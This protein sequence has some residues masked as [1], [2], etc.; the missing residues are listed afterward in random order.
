MGIGEPMLWHGGAC[1]PPKTPLHILRSEQDNVFEEEVGDLDEDIRG[2][3]DVISNLCY[4]SLMDVEHLLN[5]RSENDTLMESPTD[6]EIIQSVL[7]N[8]DDE[9]NHDDSDVIPIVSSKDAFQA[10]VTLNNY[11]LQH[12]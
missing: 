1:A 11:L 8:D 3:I 7:N 2:L 6:E 4:R 9:N 10:L 5:Y 12:E